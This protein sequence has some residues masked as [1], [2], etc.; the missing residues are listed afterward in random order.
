[1]L[2]SDKL[3][4][5]ANLKGTD[6]FR[7]DLREAILRRAN[8]HKASLEG[9]LLWSADLRMALLT[10][11]NLRGAN[12]RQAN[13]FGAN[14]EGA[15]LL[16]ARLY[17]TEM[18]RANLK[19][20]FNVNVEKL[21]KWAISLVGATMPDGSMKQNP[22]NPYSKINDTETYV[23]R[24]ARVKAQ[25]QKEE[26]WEAKKE[27]RANE[28]A[29]SIAQARANRERA[30]ADFDALGEEMAKATTRAELV[31]LGRRREDLATYTG[32]SYTY[33]N[34]CWCCGGRISSAIHARCP[35]CRWFM[36]SKRGS[37]G[38]GYYGYSNVT[39]DPFLPDYPDDLS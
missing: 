22:H 8:L 15:D 28:Y 21:E 29:K 6:L 16:E 14:L 18:I 19:G 23:E 33:E 25:T 9:A 20:A 12:L 32:N 13:L 39:V 2:L 27:A 26:E 17:Q 1:M 4:E 37:C 11:A 5:G 10:G 31:E 38:C 36:C 24:Q 7:A 3:L 30:R 34:V 35:V